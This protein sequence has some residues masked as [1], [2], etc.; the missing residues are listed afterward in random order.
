ME[1]AEV[2]TDDRKEIGQVEVNTEAKVKTEENTKGEDFFSLNLC[3]CPYLYLFLLFPVFSAGIF[4]ATKLFRDI[5]R[6]L[7]MNHGRESF[8]IGAYTPRRGCAC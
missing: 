7:H 5:F 2:S 4:F 8:T 1:Q 3:S 6:Q